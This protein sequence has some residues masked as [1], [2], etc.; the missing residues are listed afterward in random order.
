[1]KTTLKIIVLFISILL[2]SCNA[3]LNIGNGIDGSGNVITEKRNITDSFTKIDASTG[4]EVILE[5]G[6]TTEVEVEIDDNLM[7]YVIT[8]VENGTLIAKIDGNINTTEAIIIRIKTTKIDGLEASS[9]ASIRSKSNLKGTNISIKTSSGSVVNT[10]LEYEKVISEAS[11]G[12]EIT[13]LGK[14]LVVETSSS[15]GSTINAQDLAANEI[16]AEST[17]GSNTTVNPIV[18]LNAKASS[19]SSIVYVKAAKKIV[20]EESSGGSVS[21]K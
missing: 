2:T 17:S 19:G 16:T 9:G 4:V 3:N 8:K 6:T 18:L 12:S 10:D 20:K 1:M 11:S 5:Q 7:E 21:I 13:L 15:S 14:A